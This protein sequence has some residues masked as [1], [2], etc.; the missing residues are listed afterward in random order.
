MLTAVTRTRYTFFID[1]DL[2]DALATIKERDGIPE[3][4][5]IRRALRAWVD[6]KEG[7]EETSR[8]AWA[9]KRPRTI[10]R[11]RQ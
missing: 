8:R 3:S 2:R 9:G 1:S 11:R 7:N 5:Q 6:T 4:E 10:R